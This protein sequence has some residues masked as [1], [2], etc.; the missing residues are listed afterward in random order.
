MPK[1]VTQ[2]QITTYLQ[3]L[4]ETPQRI[5]SL[6]AGLD[7]SRLHAARAPGEWSVVDILAHLRGCADV[8]SYSI[9][10]MLIL[11]NPELAYIHPRAW[12]KKQDYATVRFAENFQA[13][14]VGRQ[15][16]LRILAGLSFDEW[17][18]SA[19]FIGKANTYTVFGETMRMA[20]HEF[21]HW[22]QLETTISSV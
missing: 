8:W 20:L 14:A 13:F 18:R 16:L 5:A 2:A 15:N 3:T 4:R 6:T 7:E 19:R 9:Y 17:D 12:A 11:D 22:Q 21:D 1:K 10:A